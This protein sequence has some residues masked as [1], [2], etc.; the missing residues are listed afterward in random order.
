MY[1]ISLFEK[2][3]GACG[4]SPIGDTPKKKK[5]WMGNALGEE[6]VM[7]DDVIRSNQALSEGIIAI[8]GNADRSTHA[9]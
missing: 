1:V 3:R 4:P 9:M 8:A 5:M 6:S 2:R 7:K